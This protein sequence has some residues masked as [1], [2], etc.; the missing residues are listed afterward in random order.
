ML[1][2][3]TVLRAVLSS[4][5]LLVALLGATA[6]SSSAADVQ[7]RDNCHIWVEVVPGVFEYLNICDD[8]G[9]DGGGG[10]GGGTGPICDLGE[11]PYVE[12]CLDDDMPCFADIPSPIV[13]ENWPMEDRPSPNH[14][15]TW[16]YCDDPESDIEYID[17][18]WIRPYRDSLPDMFWDA[19]GQLQT[20]AFTL[21]FTPEGMSYV[22]AKT[23]FTLD[24]LGDGEI[25]GAEAGPLQATGTLSHVEIDPG[26]G[27]PVID[28]DP[29]L[30]STACEHVYLTMSHDQIALD[31]EGRP[32]FTAQARLIYDVT[33]TIDGEEAD[34]V[35]GVP[36]TLESPWNGTLVPVGEIQALVR[37]R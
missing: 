3:R 37:S 5:A 18:D 23:R 36:N 1:K 10:G 34:Q 12:F 16:V 24:G 21:G 28:C 7:S 13:V 11:E 27:T 31:L 32:S 2:T 19:Y 20:P 8:P 17:A 33:F 9:D 30:R 14:I 4:M 25:I 26:D 22:G 6:P 35:P 29:D 15:F